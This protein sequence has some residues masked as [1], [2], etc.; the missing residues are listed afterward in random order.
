M[1]LWMEKE[2]ELLAF[3]WSLIVCGL[4]AGGHLRSWIPFH[5]FT[6]SRIPFHHLCFNQLIIK[7]ETSKRFNQLHYYLQ[8]SLSRQQHFFSFGLGPEW[9]RSLLV[10]VWLSSISLLA[11]PTILSFHFFIEEM[12]ER[13]WRSRAREKGEQS[14]WRSTK[15]KTKRGSGKWAFFVGGY[16][17]EPICAEPFHSKKFFTSFH[18]SHLALL[19]PLLKKR[20]ARSL[21][22]LSFSLLI[23]WKDKSN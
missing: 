23:N 2:I 1:N 11:Q 10:G 12:I 9:K 15:P 14:K 22:C 21:S 4:W 13:L 16:G 17:A 18:S 8:Y 7:K 19:F 3:E 5:S 6:H 20:L